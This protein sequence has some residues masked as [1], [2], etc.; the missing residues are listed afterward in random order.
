MVAANCTPCLKEGVGYSA[1]REARNTCAGGRAFDTTHFR[2]EK[3]TNVFVFASPRA[4]TLDSDRLATNYEGA[5]K[6]DLE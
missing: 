3:S 6:L 2:G 1:Q 4:E 5:L